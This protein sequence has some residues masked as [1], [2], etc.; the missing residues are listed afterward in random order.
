MDTFTWSRE[1]APGV[2]ADECFR[3]NTLHSGAGIHQ[4]ATAAVAAEQRDF[5]TMADI[6]RLATL[7]IELPITF[8]DPKPAPPAISAPAATATPTTKN[9][10]VTVEREPA[11]AV[12]DITPIK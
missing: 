9:A 8:V 10:A 11:R 1:T 3:R 7:V 6:D 5:F 12:F 4:A 2:I